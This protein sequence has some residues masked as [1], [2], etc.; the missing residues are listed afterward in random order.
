MPLLGNVSDLLRPIKP[1]RYYLVP[2]IT[3]EFVHIVLLL[4]DYKLYGE[5]SEKAYTL[6]TV[7]RYLRIQIPINCRR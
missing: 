4:E 1:L 3:R 6:Y 7:Y 2:P 5:Q